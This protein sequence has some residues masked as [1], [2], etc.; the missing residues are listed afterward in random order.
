MLALGDGVV[1][2]TSYARQRPSSSTFSSSRSRQSQDKQNK[3]RLQCHDDDAKPY[4]EPAMYH[5]DDLGN[6]LQVYNFF[7]F[8]TL[9]LTA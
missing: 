1:D 7:N 9:F 2:R 3:E 8:I 6:Y 5:L 4:A